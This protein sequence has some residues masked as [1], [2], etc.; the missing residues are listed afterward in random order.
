MT[1]TYAMKVG[2]DIGKMTDSEKIA[3]N[4]AYQSPKK[5]GK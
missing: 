5:V 4:D 3:Q 1:P 2:F